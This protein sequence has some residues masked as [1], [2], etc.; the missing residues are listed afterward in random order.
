MADDEARPQHRAEIGGRHG[1]PTVTVALPF[2]SITTVD[3]GLRDAVVDLASLVAEL[4]DHAATGSTSGITHVAEA[5]QE[6]ASR[7]ASPS[8]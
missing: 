5:A 3:S 2:S 7:L 8:S 4:A 6:L 1:S